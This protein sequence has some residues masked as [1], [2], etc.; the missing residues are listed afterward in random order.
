MIPRSKLTLV[1][2]GPGDPELITLK[3]IRALG[4]ADVVLY[5]ALVATDL[6]A[7]APKAEHIF[8]GKRKGC[9]AYLQPQINE[10][11][12]ELG[13][14]RGHVVRLKGGDPF[15]FGRGSEEMEYAEA[16]GM[17]TEIIPGLSSALAVPALRHIPLTLR[18]EA[19]SFWVVTGT[20][21]DHQLSRDVAL[22]AKSSATVVVLMGMSHLG[23]I[24]ACFAAEGK[25]GLPVAVIQ[26]GS[27][28]AEQMVVG[29]VCDIRERVTRAGLRSPAV[30]VVGEA[31]RL[32]R[33]VTPLLN[34][35]KTAGFS[36]PALIRTA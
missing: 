34:E 27:T 7:H 12:V 14:T 24:M 3:A 2:A 26:E 22:A 29:T 9:A 18:G 11:I 28:R 21:R 10:L 17:E 5:D 31:V 16:H 36:D 23:Q 8:V 30:I 1:G 19:E 15:I 33:N 6:L 4:Q 35:L 25:A 32:H 20:T 13:R